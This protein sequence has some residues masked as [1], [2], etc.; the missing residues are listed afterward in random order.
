MGRRSPKPDTHSRLKTAAGEVF[1]A[2]SYR[3]TAVDD[4]VEQAG[5]SRGS[6][7]YYFTSKADVA[8]DLQEELWSATARQADQA[9]DP[10]GDFLTNVR[11]GLDA[12]LAALKDLGAERAFLSEGFVEPTL[13]MFDDEGKKWGGHFIRDRL[14]EAMDRGEIPRQDPE[15]AARLLVEALQTLTLAALEGDDV[16]GPMRL[17]EELNRA[18]TSG[19]DID[20]GT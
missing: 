4:I 11:R 9:V 1:A 12:Y 6:F 15:Q 18:L 13:A 7:Y 2:R 16:T 5:T 3:A 10:E 17:V 20:E 19:S 14:I 8:R